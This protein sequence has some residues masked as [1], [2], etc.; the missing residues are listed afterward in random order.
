[1]QTKKLNKRQLAYSK[2]KVSHARAGLYRTFFF[3][4]FGII[5]VVITGVA[6]SASPVAWDTIVTTITGSGM[7]A[8]MA[9]IGDL[10]EISD[11]LSSPNQIGMKIWLIAHDQIDQTQV[12][13]TPNADRELGNIPLLAGEV[14]HYFDAIPDTP[15]E[16]A[17]ATKGEIITEFAKT[18]TFICAGNR[19][20]HLDFIEEYSGK[21][22]IIIYQIGEDATK[23][24]LGN[25]YKPMILMTS[26]RK[27]GGKE[28]RYITFTFQNK[29]WR[30][31]LTY[32]GSIAITAA[33]T[34]S[35][36]ATALPITSATQ[37][38]LSDHSGVAT[39]ATVSGIGSADIGR[40]IELLA[41][42]TDA[43][44]PVVADNSVFILKSAAT[45][46]ANPGSRISFK[47][48]D[49]STLVEVDGTRVQTV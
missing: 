10:G 34:V 25:S 45:W 7:L 40:V 9:A 41:P 32:V 47:I 13:P 12:F 19:N 38:Q 6:L 18:F 31:P 48:F 46:T 8:S 26:D 43:N 2:S 24:V 1:M 5:A 33:S 16:T 49:A 4:L 27:G 3:L 17:T 20:K 39:L 14:P 22:F 21:G 36:G 35:A 42:A 44:S 29:Y 11:K 28:G 37:Y 30:Q 15:D 23:Y